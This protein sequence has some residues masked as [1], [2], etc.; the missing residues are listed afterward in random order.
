MSQK[1]S[2]NVAIGPLAQPK[3][4]NGDENNITNHQA[5]P[6]L[7]INDEN[8]HHKLLPDRISIGHRLNRHVTNRSALWM[9]MWKASCRPIYLL[10]QPILGNLF[11]FSLQPIN[12]EANA[13]LYIIWAK[14]ILTAQVKI[15]SK[16]TFELPD[17]QNDKIQY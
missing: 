5:L 7:K 15:G 9:L 6:K 11:S 16:I 4:K 8:K 12:L 1:K 14:P 13:I 3:P 10:T 17:T 2:Q